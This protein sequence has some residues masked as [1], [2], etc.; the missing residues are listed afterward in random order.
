MQAS[1]RIRKYLTLA[2]ARYLFMAFVISKLNYATMISILRR[3]TCYMKVEKVYCKTHKIVIDSGE[4][5]QELLLLINN[6]L[7]IKNISNF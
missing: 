1:L 2:T 4:S 7:F 5:H 3:K 6:I